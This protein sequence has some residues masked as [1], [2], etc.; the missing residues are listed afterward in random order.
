LCQRLFNPARHGD[1]SGVPKNDV[2]LYKYMLACIKFDFGEKKQ[3]RPS[4][5]QR[6]LDR[7]VVSRLEAGF[8]R[9]HSTNKNKRLYTAARKDDAGIVMEKALDLARVI[10]CAIKGGFPTTICRY[11]RCV[12]FASTHAPNSDHNPP[13]RWDAAGDVVAFSTFLAHLYLKCKRYIRPYAGMAIQV[14]DAADSPKP[15]KRRRSVEPS[16]MPERFLTWAKGD[17][18]LAHM[19]WAAH[20]Y[21][22]TPEADTPA[23]AAGT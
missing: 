9:I 16:T 5:A 11:D 13:N 18:K 17:P 10:M 20:D 8:V 12:L 15:K 21:V 7:V 2:D 4:K 23:P 3:R 6:K 19:L 22:E 14:A 1:P